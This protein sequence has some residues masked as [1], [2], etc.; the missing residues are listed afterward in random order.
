MEKDKSTSPEEKLREQW[1][2]EPI[3]WVEVPYYANGVRAGWPDSP[4][5]L[6]Q[7]MVLVPKR[8]VTEASFVLPVKGQSMRDF[9]LHE[10]DEL[11]VEYR[12]TAEVGDIVVALVDGGDT[13]KV[14][15]ED[16]EG[17]KWLLPGNPDFTPIAL[18]PGMDVRIQGVVKHIMHKTPSVSLRECRKIM[19]AYTE[20][21][22]EE[23]PKP[24]ATGFRFAHYS[25]HAGKEDKRRIE[26]LLRTAAPKG[27]KAILDVLNAN[28]YYL[29]LRGVSDLQLHTVLQEYG[30]EKKYDSFHNQM[31]NCKC[32]R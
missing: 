1:Q 19:R 28:T 15:Y 8:F 26:G 23:E 3:E 32:M 9:D 17:N 4:G 18:K 30:L 2:P 31:K 6:E 22:T 14:Y 24:K 16:E 21:D 10:G 20:G 29:D 12:E 5:D 13:V 27:N 7:E 11:V 25:A